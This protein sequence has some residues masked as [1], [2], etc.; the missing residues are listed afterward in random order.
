[1]FPSIPIRF[2]WRSWDITSMSCAYCVQSHH[3][4][5][6][7]ISRANV[8]SRRLARAGGSPPSIPF[9][10]MELPWPYCVQSHHP[11]YQTI[12]MA[13]IG[14]QGRPW[15]LMEF[16]SLALLCSITSSCSIPDI[17]IAMGC[18]ET[19]L[20]TVCTVRYREIPKGALGSSG[21][22]DCI[23]MLGRCY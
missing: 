14:Q 22:P 15:D 8:A 16:H 18:H 11:A 13:A 5:S 19:R 7:T 9:D 21:I 4:A 10:L 1:M 20:I 17:V 12:S 6:Q 2:P 3:P 23:G